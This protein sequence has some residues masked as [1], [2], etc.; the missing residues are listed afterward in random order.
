[1][2]RRCL[3]SNYIATLQAQLIYIPVKAFPGVFKSH[4]NNFGNI[5][6]RHLPQPVVGFQFGTASKIGIDPFQILFIDLQVPFITTTSRFQAFHSVK[7]EIPILKQ[8]RVSLLQ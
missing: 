3:H 8:N 2:P 6:I 5:I 4:F 7:I 1:M